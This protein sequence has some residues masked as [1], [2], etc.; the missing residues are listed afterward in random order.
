MKKDLLNEHEYVWVK[1]VSINF[2]QKLDIMG[3]WL[4]LSKIKNWYG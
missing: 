2:N 1:Q 4:Q 3:L